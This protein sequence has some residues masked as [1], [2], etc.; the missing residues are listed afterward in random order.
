MK[1]V[2]IIAYTTFVY[3]GRVKRHA[4]AL[5][6]RGD[7]VDVIALRSGHEGLQNAVN[8][9]GIPMERYRGDSRARYM[10]SYMRFFMCAA[11]M[12][13]KLGRSN[14]Y[15]VVITCTLPDTAVLS[16]LPARLF[17]SRVILDVHD[18]MPEL[19]QDKFGGR[20]GAT[21]ARLL[22]WLERICAGFAD[23]VFAVHQ[24]HR[25]RLLKSGIPGRK[26][27][28]VMNSPEPGIFKSSNSPSDGK[29]CVLVYHGTITRR[30]GID[31]AIKAVSLLVDRISGVRLRVIGGG[32][33]T[34][35]A[36]M[37][38]ARLKVSDQVRFEGA[39]PNEQVPRLLRDAT[40]GLV[41]NH[42]SSANHLML[43]VKLMEYAALGIPVVASRLRTVEHYFPDTAVRLVKPGD[44]NAMANAV[45]ELWRDADL[46]A[47]LARN[48]HRIAIDLGWSHQEQNLF[49]AIDEL[50]DQRR[51][52]S[53]RV[54]APRESN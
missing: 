17:G 34:D 48:A 43:P 26:I 15:D 16:A 13:Y 20:R 37:L 9:I 11:R 8:L 21:G 32:D 33:Y 38:A 40:V 19:Y 29:D 22:M 7:S 27:T 2:L 51:D 1:R 5:A 41:P 4:E 44:A 18:T 3:D 46:R 25:L 45:E 31:C 24:L 28:V 47:D 54:A 23:R 14:P 36:R 35:Q 12:A 10:A 42:A 49:A 6:A 50:A 39:V 53:Q 30:L 52:P